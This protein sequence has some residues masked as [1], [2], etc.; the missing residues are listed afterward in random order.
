MAASHMTWIFL[1]FVMAFVPS[2]FAER[3]EAARS[4][5]KMEKT[6]NRL[7]DNLLAELARLRRENADLIMKHDEL[8]A[9]GLKTLSPQSPLVGD[10][11]T[12]SLSDAK[13]AQVHERDSEVNPFHRASSAVLS[14]DKVLETF[15]QDH[16]M[17]NFGWQWREVKGK[18]EGYSRSSEVDNL[19]FGG[20]DVTLWV[21]D[22][23]HLPSLAILVNRTLTPTKVN[24]AVVYGRG[25]NIGEA[26]LGILD[27][28][29]ATAVRPNVSFSIPPS[30]VA[31]GIFNI[32]TRIAYVTANTIEVEHAYDEFKALG[33]IDDSAF[34]DQARKLGLIATDYLASKFHVALSEEEAEF[35]VIDPSQDNLVVADP[36]ALQSMR[37]TLAMLYNNT[38][39]QY[40]PA[41]VSS[42]KYVGNKRWS[43]SVRVMPDA[44][45][46]RVLDREVTCLMY[47]PTLED[48]PP[49]PPPDSALADT[50][51]EESK[52]GL[53][54]FRVAVTA[55]EKSRMPKL[56]IDK[57]FFEEKQKTLPFEPGPNL[58][59]RYHHAE[60]KQAYLRHRVF[61]HVFDGD[62][63]GAI[64]FDSFSAVVEHVTRPAAMTFLLSNERFAMGWA[65]DGVEVGTGHNCL[66][67]G[68][69]EKVYIAG[70]ILFG[71]DGVEF[72][73]QSGTFTVR[74][75]PKY[76]AG[77]DSHRRQWAGL[78]SALIG[79]GW[80]SQGNDMPTPQVAYTEKVLI[81][82]TPPVPATV[83]AFCESD[84][85]PWM[86]SCICIMDNASY[87]NYCEHLK[88]GVVATSCNHPACHP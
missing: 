82:F 40:L 57:G 48:V 70:E 21:V 19:P 39:G 60:R 66:I 55:A 24:Y 5:L 69:A 79:S 8:L 63:T 44:Q 22:Y 26:T 53:D 46:D 31:A 52:P 51:K 47:G 1:F 74:I 17:Q 43:V 23:E 67:S 10:S 54:P 7:V 73:F 56:P 65:L 80:R 76:H 49:P 16:G 86:R 45:S 32:G 6:A 75:S 37:Q 29:N 58:F 15:A 14:E 77:R 9:A 83:E 41:M 35:A 64:P 20:E 28:L 36:S 12:E 2:T 72:N 85:Q 38:N 13:V 87:V 78:I 59:V 61:E 50:F 42:A 88:K 71:E 30:G 33:N 25:D 62:H 68:L 34:H 18:Y 84:D 81:P 27:S 11:F 4:G 3:N